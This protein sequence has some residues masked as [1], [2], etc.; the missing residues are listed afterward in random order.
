MSMSA[1]ARPKRLAILQSNYIPWKGYFDIINS[2]DEFWIYDCFQ[3]TRYDWRNRNRIKTPHGVKWLTIPVKA[4]NHFNLRIDE[5]HAS[6]NHWRRR[7]W[8]TLL[9]CYSRAPHFHRYRDIFES[10]YLSTAETSLS[11]INETLIRIICDL[12]GIKTR[13]LSV[14]QPE[15]RQDKTSRIIRLCKQAGASSHLFGPSARNYLNIRLF[16]QSG[17]QDVWMDYSGYPEYEQLYPPFV[18]EVSIL[19]LLFAVG[20]DAPLYMRSFTSN[21]RAAVG[22]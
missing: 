15:H 10:F 7:H 9:Y 11:Q 8:Q 4:R 19:D 3:Y 20:P 6:D 22:T 14:T 21:S 13:I 17:L 16:R 12:L 2:V 18:H 1:V 5:V